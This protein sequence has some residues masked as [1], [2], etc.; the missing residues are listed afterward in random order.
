MQQQNQSSFYP[1]PIMNYLRVLPNSGALNV[2]NNSVFM[3]QVGDIELGVKIKLYI[4]IKSDIITRV[5]YLVYGDGYIIA[6]LGLMSE[7]LPGMKISRAT[8]YSLTKVTTSLTIPVAKNNQ[9]K[10]L[11]EA[12]ENILIQ[13]KQIHGK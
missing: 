4:E 2:D 6:A 9:I 13:Y 8:N 3:A 1:E 5:K 7:E 12:L 10:L 11:K